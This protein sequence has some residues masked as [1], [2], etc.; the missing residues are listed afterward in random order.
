M[1]KQ[2]EPQT[3]AAAT[4]VLRDLE[5]KRDECLRRGQELTDM[6]RERA[7]QTHAVHD[8][9]AQRELADVA[10]AIAVNDGLLASVQEAVDFSG[11]NNVPRV[12]EPFV[13]PNSR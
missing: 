11:Q 1:T 9:D 2:H 8:P 13:N 6:R 10:A 7:Y 12:A 3:V 5:A 4:A